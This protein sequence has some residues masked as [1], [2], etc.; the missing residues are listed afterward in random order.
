MHMAS[1]V[2]LRKDDLWCQVLRRPTQG[3]CSAFDS[4]RKPKVGDLYVGGMGGWS[5][6]GLVGQ[7]RVR[8]GQKAEVDTK[9]GTQVWVV[10]HTQ[11]QLKLAGCST[12]R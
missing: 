10:L 3:P 8:E 4:L 6:W 11:P 12:K 7:N 9:G 1:V 5:E 2:Y